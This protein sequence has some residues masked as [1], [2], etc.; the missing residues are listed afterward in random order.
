MVPAIISDL[1]PGMMIIHNHPSGDLS[2]SAAD[3]RVASRTGNNGIGF[4]IINNEVTDIYVVVVPKILDEEIKIDK[5]EIIDI[6]FPGGQM[7]KLLRDYEYREQQL[8]V[9]EK[10]IDSF[11]EHRYLFVE[12]GTGT[13]KSFAYLLPALYWSVKNKECVVVST[14]TINLQEQLM[15]KDLICLKNTAFFL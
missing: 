4:A 13:G 11:N 6:F 3:I 14:N 15:G 7:E 10:I 12:A 1:K 2:P 8:A 9:L 5:D